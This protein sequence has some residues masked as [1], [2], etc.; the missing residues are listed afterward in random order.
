MGL[1]FLWKKCQDLSGNRTHT[2]ATLLPR[3]LVAQLVEHHT[4]DVRVCVQFPL[5]QEKKISRLVYK[6]YSSDSLMS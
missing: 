6:C 1:N 4:G 3:G 5:I 2:L